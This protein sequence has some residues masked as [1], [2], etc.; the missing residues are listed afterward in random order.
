MLYLDI[1]AEYKI[2]IIKSIFILLFILFV[3]FHPKYLYFNNVLIILGDVY[4]INKKSGK[5]IGQVLVGFAAIGAVTWGT[6]EFFGFN[7]VEL[8]PLVW[9][10]SVVY[11]GVAL[12]GLLVLYNMFS[13]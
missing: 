10:Q 11:G 7:A 12:G 13:K 1:T 9:L 3:V 5:V 4:M 8:I 6:S 2:I